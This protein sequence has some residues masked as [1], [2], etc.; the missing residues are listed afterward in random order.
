MKM[1]NGASAIICKIWNGGTAVEHNYNENDF[2]SLLDT[3][4]PTIGI[5][6]AVVTI[7]N[8]NLTCSYTRDNQNANSKYWNINTNPQPY[9]IMAFGVL[10]AGL[11]CLI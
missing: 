9:I 8:G 11:F 3:T 4:N 6:N 5:T 2:S 10:G 1:K 7:V